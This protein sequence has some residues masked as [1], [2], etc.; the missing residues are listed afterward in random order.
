MRGYKLP[1]ALSPRLQT[2]ASSPGITAS[3]QARALLSLQLPPT[4]DAELDDWTV[5]DVAAFGADG[6]GGGSSGW[7]FGGFA[8]WC[9]FG[10]WRGGCYRD[11]RRCRALELV[12]NLQ[13]SG[14]F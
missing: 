8:G 7:L 9:G 4:L 10:G 13:L 6:V 14:E 5:R 12:F 1:P 3:S 2:T 11:K